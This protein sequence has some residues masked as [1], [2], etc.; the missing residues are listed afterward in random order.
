MSHPSYNLNKSHGS[1]FCLMLHGHIPYVKKAGVWPFGEEWL[2]EGMLETYIPIV[3]DLIYGVIMPRA[4][5]SG[6][7][8]TPAFNLGITP[9][10]ADQLSDDYFKNRFVEFAR[11]KI[12]RAESDARRFSRSRQSELEALALWYKKIFTERLE[13]FEKIRGDILGEIRKAADAGAVEVV[14]SAAT[15]AY[16]PLLSRDSSVYA[17]IKTGIDTHTRIFGKK[18]AGFWLPECAYRPAYYAIVDDTTGEKVLRKGLDDYLAGEGI[19]YFFVDTHAVEGGVPLES[20]N[21]DEEAGDNNKTTGDSARPLNGNSSLKVYRSRNS[22]VMVL[23]R[24]RQ[25]GMLV[26]SADVGYPGDGV[27]REFHKKDSESGLQYWRVTSKN[28]DLGGKEIYNIAAAREKA[29]EHA[30]HFKSVVASTLRRAFESGIKPPLGIAA[31]YDAELY[32]HWW[33]EGV[34]W[35][36]DLFSTVVAKENNTV[37]HDNGDDEKYFNPSTVSEYLSS[38]GKTPLIDIPES[39]WGSGGGHYIWLNKETRWMWNLIYEC[40]GIMEETA[41]AYYRN[42]NNSGE[43]RNGAGST[44]P[45]KIRYRILSQ[46]VKEK[47]L[48]ESSDWEFLVT[49][50]QAREYAQ[51]RFLSH[52]NRFKKLREMFSKNNRHPNGSGFSDD[53]MR[54]LEALS[55]VDSLFG[56]KVEPRYFL[57]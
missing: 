15:H 44:I 35:L 5:K 46:M 56:Q 3:K 39:S 24:H 55:S 18:P 41:R 21:F 42:G 52:Y 11:D 1:Y 54:F 38:V 50:E 33:G 37:S 45:D 29:R 23:A 2:L 10:L 8:T 20:Y 26:W 19:R 36:I 25:T 6:G 57:K 4:G 17:Q 51:K 53:E 40:E 9:V 30:R 32:G 28:I 7:G 22:G 43:I 12:R 27:Y 47:F 16:L 31:P 14:T 34:E 49:T 48:L 13:Y